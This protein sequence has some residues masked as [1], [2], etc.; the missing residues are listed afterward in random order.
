MVLNL[1]EFGHK[2][3]GCFGL[4]T[5]VLG[6]MQRVQQLATQFARQKNRLSFPGELDFE[7]EN[8]HQA[9]R[10]RNLS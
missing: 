9:L 1:P 8:H 7:P 4:M 5:K 10:K 6:A 3:Q 2:R